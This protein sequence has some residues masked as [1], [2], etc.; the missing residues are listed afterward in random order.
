[1]ALR[2]NG[3]VVDKVSR[4]ADES[5]RAGAFKK[6]QMFVQQ[7]STLNIHRAISSLVRL[8]IREEGGRSLAHLQGVHPQNWG[9]TEPKRN[10]TCMMLKALDYD[11]RNLTSCLNPTPLIGG[12]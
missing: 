3:G 12:H 6:D 7:G 9:G 1:M 10:V 2:N 11:R 5:S 8:V 4:C